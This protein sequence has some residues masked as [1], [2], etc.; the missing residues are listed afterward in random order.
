MED[1]EIKREVADALASCPAS[2]E[3]DEGGVCDYNVCIF[4]LR[5]GA[6]PFDALTDKSSGASTAERNAPVSTPARTQNVA[7]RLPTIIK[8]ID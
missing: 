1:D 3:D 5:P 6:N 8:F 2:E 4:K 7:V